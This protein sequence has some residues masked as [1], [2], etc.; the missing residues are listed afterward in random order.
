[1]SN[2]VTYKNNS[3]SNNSNSDSNGDTEDE[4]AIKTYIQDTLIK[5]EIITK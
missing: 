5:H 4:N 1:M 3:T 2:F